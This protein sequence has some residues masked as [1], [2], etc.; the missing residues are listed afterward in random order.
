MTRKQREALEAL[1][2]VMDEY[3]LSIEVG[4]DGGGINTQPETT[5]TIFSKRDTLIEDTWKM[6]PNSIGYLLD[7][8]EQETEWQEE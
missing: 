7:E 8:L 2:D 3:G 6:D 1:R 4:S 5:L